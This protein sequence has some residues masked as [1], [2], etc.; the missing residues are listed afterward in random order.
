MLGYELLNEPI[1]SNHSELYGELHPMLKRLT[2]AIRTV[3]PNHIV[4]WG[5]ANYNEL[6]EGIF[7]PTDAVFSVGN[8]DYDAN[9]MFAC[10]R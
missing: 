3:D 7:D 8:K 10:N 6:F 2:L 4:M 5:G 1:S 9:I